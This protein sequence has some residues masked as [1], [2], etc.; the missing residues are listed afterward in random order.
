M[1]GKT[2]KISDFN[3]I[4]PR[5]ELT[6]EQKAEYHARAKRSNEGKK[7]TEFDQYYATKRFMKTL[8]K[9]RKLAGTL[10]FAA[11]ILADGYK[12]LAGIDMLGYFC[13]RGSLKTWS[14][15]VGKSAEKVQKEIETLPFTIDQ[16]F[17]NAQGSFRLDMM[18]NKKAFGGAKDF[19][20][21]RKMFFRGVKINRVNVKERLLFELNKARSIDA[22]NVAADK[23]IGWTADVPTT[24]VAKISVMN[25]LDLKTIATGLDCPDE[26]KRI[27]F[28]LHETNC[29]DGEGRK[30]R[31]VSTRGGKTRT[32]EKD[33]GGIK[34]GRL[35]GVGKA[36]RRKRKRDDIEYDDYVEEP[37]EDDNEELNEDDEKGDD[38][39]GDED[40]D[41]DDDE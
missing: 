33:G 4:E 14:V 11:M 25:V 17:F 13:I 19:D 8:P 20:Y 22:P 36:D 31:K 12:N 23:D 9:F 7:M 26:S 24:D 15:V 18:K 21:S 6:E 41:E 16:M 2:G 1:E 29:H 38:K 40:D 27:K 28:V 3:D 37:G 30:K 35:D 32:S 34:K 5:L 10:I 39:D